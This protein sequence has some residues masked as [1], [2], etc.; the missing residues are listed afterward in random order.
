[1]GLNYSTGHWAETCTGRETAGEV[2]SVLDGFSATQM[3][4]SDKTPC[5]PQLFLHMFFFLSGLNAL[6]KNKM[7]ISLHKLKLLQYIVQYR[8]CKISPHQIGYTSDMVK[9]GSC[10]TCKKNLN[11]DPQILLCSHPGVTAPEPPRLQPRLL[12]HREVQ[13]KIKKKKC[14][15][16]RAKSHLQLCR[17]SLMLHHVCC[18]F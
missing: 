11:Q 8:K 3:W 12:R 18:Q 10:F 15:G 6:R 9:Y 16:E 2:Q 5:N 17:F 7:S 1:M 13:L 4:L 14:Y